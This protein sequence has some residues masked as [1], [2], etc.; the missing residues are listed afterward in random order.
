MLDR[1]WS[2]VNKNASNGCW[3]WLGAITTAGYG[4]FKVYDYGNGKQLVKSAHH[5]AWYIQKGEWP[6]Y[7]CH[8]CDNRKC[9]NPNH[10][11]QGSPKVNSL[12]MVKKNRAGRASSRLT[13]E[14]VIKIRNDYQNGKTSSEIA[15][16]YRLAKTTVCKILNGQTWKNA[17]GQIRDRGVRYWSNRFGS[18]KTG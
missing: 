10:L 2:K 5:V 18:G 8:T 15:S 1:F 9:V 11:F 6:S 13:K 4:Q 3:E 7:L 17:G 12:D 16:K 14:D